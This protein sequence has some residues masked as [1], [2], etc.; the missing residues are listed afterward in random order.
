[1]IRGHVGVKWG[2]V[3]SNFK[4]ELS[5]TIWTNWAEWR[6][7]VEIAATPSCTYLLERTKIMRE[8]I[9]QKTEIEVWEEKRRE[10]KRREERQRVW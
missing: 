6:S 7:P 2:S 10:E 4:P 5:R 1:M 3:D 9:K 8:K